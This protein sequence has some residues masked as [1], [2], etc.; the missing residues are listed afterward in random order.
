MPLLYNPLHVISVVKAALL[1][2][3]AVTFLFIIYLT[4]VA[5]IQPHLGKR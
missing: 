1:P 3:P 4:T 2:K 5:L